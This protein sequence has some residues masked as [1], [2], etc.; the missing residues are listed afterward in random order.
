MIAV[1]FVLVAALATL[2]RAVVTANQPNGQIPWRTL[3]VNVAGAF[4]LGIVAASHW[5]D[6]PV[7]ATSAGLGSLTTFST[8]AAETAG[9]L[10][11]GRKRRAIAY[12][13]LTVVVGIAAAWLGLS[14]GD[15]S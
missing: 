8:V 14:I 2:L 12:V 13:G 11:D 9:L 3:G 7:I 1:G 10:D 6:N 5:W 4:L 15:S